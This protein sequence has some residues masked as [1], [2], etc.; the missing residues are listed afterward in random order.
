MHDV[1]SSL[2]KQ[3]MIN[4]DLRNLLTKPSHEHSIPQVQEQLSCSIDLNTI[5]NLSSLGPDGIKDDVQK[6]IQV[7][8]I[9]SSKNSTMRNKGFLDTIRTVLTS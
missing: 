5:A 3:H 4:Q 8:L 9:H 7:L 6:V 1:R 2:A